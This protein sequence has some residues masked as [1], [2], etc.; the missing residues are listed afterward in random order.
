MKITRRATLLLPFS[1]AVPAFAGE[2]PW[3]ARVLSGGFDGEVHH[4]GLLVQLQPGWK[5]YWRVPGAGGIPPDISATGNNLK[6]VVVAHPLPQRF[7]GEDGETIGY[8]DEVVFPVRLV[9]MDREKPVSVRFTTFLGV[10]DVVCIPVKYEEQHVLRPAVATL[11]DFSILQHWQMQVPEAVEKGPIRAATASV[12]A[13]QVALGLA[14][15]EPVRDIFVE[16]SAMHYFN[17]PVFAAG[18]L[19]ATLTVN[20]AKSA[21]EVQGQSLRVTL[22]TGRRGLEQR[23]LVV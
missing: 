23:T 9:P 16:G 17:A 11:P 15:A 4:A 10:C 6:D 3:Q 13:G 2:R 21:A 14:L 8:K 1:V 18:G 22:S 12:V 7:A 19:S 20:G 5:T